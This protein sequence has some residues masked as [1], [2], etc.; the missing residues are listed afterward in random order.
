MRVLAIS[1]FIGLCACASAASADKRCEEVETRLAETTARLDDAVRRITELEA[2][3]K[4]AKAREERLL[5]LERG[6]EP[7]VRAGNSTPE[8][9]ASDELDLDR[10]LSCEDGRCTITRAGL[11]QLLANPARLA[12]Q[13]RLVPSLRDGVAEGF[14]IYGIRRNTLP[15]RL[16]FENGDLVVAIN[17]R[18]VASLDQAMQAYSE[19][20]GA[21]QIEFD[22]RREN[23]P[24]KLTLLI[25]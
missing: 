22:V 12:T 6:L 17:G 5:R 21:S 3:A 8:V 11:E 19:L 15:A 24:K 18:S 7:A 25:E 4:D 16:G 1:S 14:K 13:A 20:K 10:I 2:Q 9:E 23:E